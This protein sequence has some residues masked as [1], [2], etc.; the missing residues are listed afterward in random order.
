L[1][2]FLIIHATRNKCNRNEFQKRN[3]EYVFNLLL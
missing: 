1:I 2:Q 3:E